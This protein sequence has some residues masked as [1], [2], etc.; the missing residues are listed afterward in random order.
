[1]IPFSSI[2]PVGTELGSFRICKITVHIYHASERRRGGCFG[3][4]RRSRN[5]RFRYAVAACDDRILGNKFNLALLI[6]SRHRADDPLLVYYAAV[7][8]NQTHIRGQLSAF[9][10]HGF[11]ETALNVNDEGGSLIARRS[12]V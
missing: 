4:S 10:V 3:G 6:D 11:A 9:S 5:G 12:A 7:H 8:T 2:S 1:M